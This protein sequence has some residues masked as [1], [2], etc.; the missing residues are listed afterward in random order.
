MI[1]RRHFHWALLCATLVATL[2]AHALDCPPGA[3]R[4]LPLRND[5]VLPPLRDGVPRNDDVPR[6]IAIWGDSHIAA[7]TFA[8]ELQRVLEA[9]GID[10]RRRFVA[11]YFD[12]AGVALAV[13]GFCVSSGWRS[14]VAFA[15][16]EAVDHGPALA[17]LATQMPD[18]YIHLDLRNRNDAAD[19]FGLRILFEAKPDDAGAEPIVGIT[20]DESEEQV[21]RLAGDEH[22]IG[23]LALARAAPIAGVRLRVISGRIAV[24][25]IT[26]RRAAAT[27]PAVE[28]DVFGIPGA[29][30]AGWANAQPEA[31]IAALGADAYDLVALEYG[32]NEGNA[33][34]VAARYRE[35]LER[36]VAQL[37]ATFPDARCVLIGPPDRGVRGRKPRRDKLHY[38]RIHARINAVQAEVAAARGCLHFDWQRSMGGPGSSYDYAR[39]KPPLMS[40]DLIHLTRAGTRRAANEFARFLGW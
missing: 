12:R 5:E 29:T 13:R 37:R 18:E 36:G 15:A 25:G 19:V 9:R 23:E 14:D 4:D 24:R 30:V 17:K 1:G 34:F 7:G 20:L 33:P 3:R 27:R 2:P 32:T 11:P 22:G 26:Q 39:A 6:R 31:M 40:G 8:A 28:I 21:V 16:R 10:V 35:L 38:A